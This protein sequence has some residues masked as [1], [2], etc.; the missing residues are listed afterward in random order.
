MNFDFDLASFVVGLIV[1]AAAAFASGFF[2]KAGE[3]TWSMLKQ[4]VFPIDPNPVAVPN[5]FNPQQYEQG[6]FAWVPEADAHESEAQGYRYFR[7]PHGKAKVF[8][9]L[10]HR[11]EF[12]MRRPN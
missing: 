5:D 12:L 3:D 7:H 2:K 4:R 9:T 1:G 10:P 8:R 6:N 11:K